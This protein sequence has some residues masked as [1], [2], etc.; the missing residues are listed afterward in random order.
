[1]RI[2]LLTESLCAD[3][4]WGRYATELVDRLGRKGFE[5][6]V[7]ETQNLPMRQ[8]RW[9]KREPF[10]TLDHG[11][12]VLQQ[13]VSIRSRV[14]DCDVIHA[15]TERLA[16]A[17]AIIAGR[18]RFVFNAYG[19]F[20]TRPLGRLL[21]RP[22]A[23]A[24]Y[25]RASRIACIS[26]YTEKRIQ[27]LLPEARTTIVPS[28]VDFMRFQ[29]SEPVENCDPLTILIV[30]AVKPRKGHHVL[31]EALAAVRESV[32]GV[33]LRVAGN[34]DFPDY[35]RSLQQR[36]QDLRLEDAVTFLGRVDETQLIKEYHRCA[37]FVL[38]SMNVGDAYEGYP[39]VFAEAGACGR[40]V[41][42]THGNGSEEAVSDGVNGLLVPQGDV[43]ATADAV[44]RLLTDHELSSRLGA[45]GRERARLLTW[46]R[47]ADAFA[48]IY[49][50]LAPAR[51]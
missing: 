15:M 21:R 40:P 37:V 19:T 26:R 14:R 27:G 34:P 22:F 28:G 43:A 32:P 41:I 4:G 10:L 30:G 18:R 35:F 50:E 42:G 23:A 38:P 25:R 46:D 2:G 1:M 5:L 20:A 8:L 48:T 44:S 31:L 11:L 29:S 17:A 7:V 9:H 12:R 16:P 47:T 13:T 49:R 36:V 51:V 24:I 3:R 33:R 39:L 6:V 45:Q